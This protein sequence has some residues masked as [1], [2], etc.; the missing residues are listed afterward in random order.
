[1]L[2]RLLAMLGAKLSELCFESNCA[3]KVLPAHAVCEA[4][5]QLQSPGLDLR[6]S[7]Q[8]QLQ[9]RCAFIVLLLQTLRELRIQSPGLYV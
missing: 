1:M 2:R 9:S 8:L 7:P 6:R 4:R 3:F 5:L